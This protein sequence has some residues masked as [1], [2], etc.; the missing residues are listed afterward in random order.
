LTADEDPE[1]ADWKLLEGL[2]REAERL[3]T[4]WDKV[5][6]DVERGINAKGP[7]GLPS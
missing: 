1:N 2:W 6:E 4:G 3:A 7:I 5:I